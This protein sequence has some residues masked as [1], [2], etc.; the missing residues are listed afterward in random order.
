MRQPAPPFKK[1]GWKANRDIHSSH[2]KFRVSSSVVAIIDS[3]E[4]KNLQESK[5]SAKCQIV[6]GNIQSGLE[7]FKSCSV[8]GSV[9]RLTSM[10][11]E[12]IW[13]KVVLNLIDRVAAIVINAVQDVV[14][15]KVNL[16]RWK[17]RQQRMPPL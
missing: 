7:H 10:S 5:K 8:K 14:P 9:H 3:S 13:S 17:N 11:V 12:R 16:I 1:L 15:H 2:Y 4:A 6:K